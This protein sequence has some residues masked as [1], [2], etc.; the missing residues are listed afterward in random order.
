MNEPSSNECLWKGPPLQDMLWDVLVRNR[1]K[2]V[3]SF[4]KFKEAFLQIT[5]RECE[6]DILRFHWIKNQNVSDIEILRFRRLVFG[7]I[8]SPFIL[9]AIL[10]SHLSKYEKSY[11]K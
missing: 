3:A 8:Q 7:L 10:P 1:M 5:I 4:C 2:P 9:E 11:P 6:K